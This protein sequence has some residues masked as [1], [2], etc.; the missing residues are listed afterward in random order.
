MT[1]KVQNEN[2]PDNDVDNNDDEAVS[3]FAQIADNDDPAKS[4][5]GL[6]ADLDDEQL[7]QDEDEQNAQGKGD[8]SQQEQQDADPWQSAPEPLRN[9]FNQ[10]RQANQQL[11][12]QYNAV[13]GRLA[14]T[15]RELDALKKQLAEKEQQKVDGQKSGPTA[16]E[17][18]GMTDE[19]LEQ[20]WPELAAAL[21]RREQQLERKFDERLSPLQQQLEQQR[22]FERQQQEQHARQQELGRLAQVHPD[23]QQVVSNPAFKQWLSA[24]PPGVQQ[25]A[26]SMSADDNIALLNLYKTATGKP[27]KPAGNR[28]QGKPALRD[29]A[30]LPRRGAGR[31][32]S[33]PNNADPVELFTQIAT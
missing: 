14:P 1:T 17:I 29:Q 30:E 21:K 4:G 16:D 23:Y 25:I 12:N 32:A 3:L 10:L 9:E 20:E 8:D 31:A 5:S 11:Q 24:Q 26:S 13:T 33:D 6:D 18:A 7:D 2:L 28:S 15:Q 19:E 27:A 22:E